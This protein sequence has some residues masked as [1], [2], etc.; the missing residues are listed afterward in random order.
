MKKNE[1][2]DKLLPLNKELIVKDMDRSAIA[3][4]PTKINERNRFGGNALYLM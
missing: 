3:K 1:I 4:S 2:Y